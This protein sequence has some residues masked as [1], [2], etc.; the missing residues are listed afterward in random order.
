LIVELFG[1]NQ[2][3]E[4]KNKFEFSD[5]ANVP[6]DSYRP[7]RFTKFRFKWNGEKFIPEG[8]PELLDDDLD[9]KINETLPGKSKV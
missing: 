6:K 2:F 7:R 4:S 5:E 9:N 3:T 8:E 1:K